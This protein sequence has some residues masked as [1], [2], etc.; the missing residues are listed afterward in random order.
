[1]EWIYLSPHLDDAALSMGGLIWEQVQAGD[2]VL[3]WTIC[4]GDPPPG[5]FSDFAESLHERWGVG[6]EAID[7]RRSEDQESCLRLGAEPHHFSLPDCIYR[8]SPKTG[9]HLYDSEES[10]WFDVHPDELA[11]TQKLAQQL[12]SLLPFS[13]ARVVCPLALG[14]HVDHRLTRAAAEQIQTPLVY[15]ADY[16]YVLDVDIA[17]VTG[18]LKSSVSTLSPEAINAW[19]QAVAAHQSQISTFWGSLAEMRTA[20]Q[21]YYDQMDGV[22][23]WTKS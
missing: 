21:S 10:L 3:V 7:I 11:R 14:D 5:A 12:Q 23:L 2:S 9:T 20:I 8:R 1:M 16:P 17:S 18:D 15:Y 4:A 22:W 19:Q 6:R 13:D